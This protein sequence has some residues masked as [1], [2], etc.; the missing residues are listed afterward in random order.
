MDIFGAKYSSPDN[1]TVDVMWNHPE[2][3]EIPCTVTMS[4]S[5]PE[6]SQAAMI[7]LLKNMVIMPYTPDIGALAD[8]V[9]ADRD[10]RIDAVTWRYERHARE[11][12]LGMVTTDNL[13]TLDTYVQALADVPNQPGFP[14]SVN[15]PDE[16]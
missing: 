9:R 1:S 6:P 12:R 7:D 13:T 14:T 10:A 5:D 15:W 16:V 4:G 8:T 2:Y 11:T 3:G